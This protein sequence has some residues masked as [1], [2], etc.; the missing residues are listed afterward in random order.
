MHTNMLVYY[1]HH[2][3]TLTYILYHKQE[4]VLKSF[5]KSHVHMHMNIQM[6]ILVYI[7]NMYI[8]T[9]LDYITNKSGFQTT[10]CNYVCVYI[11]T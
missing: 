10:S 4:R 2:V 3:Y 5:L 9:H 8:Y 11:L 7:A 6:Y 1:I